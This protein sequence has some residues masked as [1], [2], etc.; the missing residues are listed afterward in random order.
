MKLNKLSL[1]T[2]LIASFTLSNAVKANIETEQFK[3]NGFYAQA[4]AHANKREYYGVNEGFE[5]ID[6]A[7][8]FRWSDQNKYS[9]AGQVY[10]RN[11][12][13]LDS[14][15]KIDYLFAG[16]DTYQNTNLD[17]KIR[18]GRVKNKFGIYN[19]TRD[20]PHSLPGAS[21]P[22]MLYQEAL[23]DIRMTLDGLSFNLLSNTID[24]TFETQV[25][26]GGTRSKQSSDLKR[27]IEDLGME[28]YL[29]DDLPYGAV[30]LYVDY[31]PNDYP[32]LNFGFSFYR[33]S[34]ELK[35]GLS[36]TQIQQNLSEK[37]VPLMVNYYVDNG[38]NPLS[39]T[40]LQQQ[41][42]QE[43]AL[44]QQR[45]NLGQFV[46][47]VSIKGD[48]F[49]AHLQYQFHQFLLSLEYLVIKT[50]FVAEN[51]TLGIYYAEKNKLNQSYY[52]QIEWQPT[53]Q[54]VG[55]FRYA[56]T[57][58]DSANEQEGGSILNDIIQVG[59]INTFAVRWYIQ[60]NLS[61]TYEYNDYDGKSSFVND[62][63]QLTRLGRWQYSLLKIIYDF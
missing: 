61:L 39:P 38:I 45:S 6:A 52:A 35:D 59:Q 17:L 22:T 31:S 41:A 32:N 2:V 51:K 62:Q 53:N 63:G 18:V 5:F 27:Y 48:F 58:I 40:T 57:I 44:S 36:A 14:D 34:V 29:D 15:T 20:V 7:L 26:I 49:G 55:L 4:Y 10:H 43:Y 56:D 30:S 37:V 33:S 13:D 3:V 28:G 11:Y 16:L 12:G 54:L 19:E 8:N 50:D 9:A 23:R 42:A 60:S 1:L 46:N 21:I 47:D 24:G 25:N